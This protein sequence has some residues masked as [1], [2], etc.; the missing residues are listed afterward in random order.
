MS[1]KSFG[2]VS[3]RVESDRGDD[4]R[5][6]SACK[7]ESPELFFPVGTS[8]P[9][10][11]QVEQAKAV[12]RRCPVRTDC[13]DWSIEAGIADGVWGGLSEEEREQEMR[14]R[15]LRIVRAVHR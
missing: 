7:D 12:C 14:T 2:F 1:R 4:W 8:G 9:A 5:K 10:L 11:M 13:R 3:A 6:R 15:G